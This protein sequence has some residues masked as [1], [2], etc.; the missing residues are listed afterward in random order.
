[1]CRRE[2]P[3]G[4]RSCCRRGFAGHARPLSSRQV[5]PPSSLE[6][7]ILRHYAFPASLFTSGWFRVGDNATGGD[8]VSVRTSERQDCACVGAYHFAHH[9]AS[10]TRTI[11]MVRPRLVARRRIRIRASRLHPGAVIPGT[12][13]VHTCAR[14]RRHERPPQPDD[15]R[16]HTRPP[17]RP[18]P[19]RNQALRERHVRNLGTSE[20]GSSVV[21]RMANASQDFRTAE[22]EKAALE[23]CYFRRCVI[24]SNSPRSNA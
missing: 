13:P 11:L 18:T 15:A 14:S 21:G 6:A 8:V 3:R 22:D 1:M 16:P 23:C 5:Q 4:I 7:G 24:R 9:A 20:L 17:Q 2:G 12:T 10:T 19:P